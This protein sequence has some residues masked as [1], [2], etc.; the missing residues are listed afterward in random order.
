LAPGVRDVE[1]R[2]HDVA[3][4]G[5]VFRSSFG[6]NH[7]QGFEEVPLG[8]GQVAWVGHALMVSVLAP[9]ALAK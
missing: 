3:Q 2:I 1:H 7:E 5:P 9:G 8:I 6:G 4:V